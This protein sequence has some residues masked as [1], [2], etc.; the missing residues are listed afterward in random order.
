M[1]EWNKRNRELI[2]VTFIGGHRPDEDLVICCDAQEIPTAV[3]GGMVWDLNPLRLKANFINCLRF[4]SIFDCE[5]AHTKELLE[6]VKYLLFCMI[7]FAK[8]GAA[9]RLSAEVVIKY[10]NLLRRAAR[11]C[12]A[13]GEKPLVGVLSLQDLFTNPIYLASFIR[14]QGEKGTG[15]TQRKALKAI[16]M[17]MVSFGEE[18]LGYRL[19]G[20]FDLDFDVHADHKQH[21]VIPLRIYFRY[22]GLFSEYLDHISLYAR[23][24]SAFLRECKDPAYACSHKCQ[25]NTHRLFNGEYKLDFRQAMEIHG[26][27]GFFVDDF[28]CSGRQFLSGVVLRAQFYLKMIIHAYTGMRDQEVMR[29]RYDCLRAAVVREPLFAEDSSV[30]DPPQIIEVLSSTTKFAGYDQAASWIATEEVVKAVELAQ[31]LC[32]EL[33]GIYD[34]DLD[35]APLFISPAVLS[36]RVAKGGVSAW[37]KDGRPGSIS[38]VFIEPDDL[39]QLCLSDQER[40]FLS[41]ERFSVGSPWPLTSHQFR[42]SLVFYGSSSGLISLPSMKRQMKHVSLSM[43]RYYR[44]GFEKI[45]SVFGYF[46]TDKGEYV[47]PKSHVA[48]DFQMAM[49]IG[50][51]YDL[52]T[53]VF[54][55]ESPLFGGVGSYVE[56]QR[57]VI[58]NGVSVAD[59][60]KETQRLVDSGRM[61]YRRTLLGGCTKVGECDSYMLGDVTA[62]LECDGAVINLRQL[63]E[64]RMDSEQELKLYPADSGEYQIILREL[65]CLNGF[66]KRHVQDKGLDNE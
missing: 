42:R 36:R 5:D 63:K 7:F 49:P 9:G 38:S 15:L 58:G 19:R 1:N 64:A 16:L 25:N 48:F 12:Y 66:Y 56:K 45:S 30:I 46:D 55:E 29:M 37:D 8:G 6:E 31:M 60:R 28:A 26:L 17:H 3:Y 18:R 33:C 41:D 24:L 65:E 14:S 43:T 4:C 11:F 22:L 61:A 57:S 32:R 53:N 50:V 35:G 21:P 54:G 2:S 23:R 44:K 51:A 10:F 47:L 39:H 59:L 40:D 27:K 62:C 34:I 52:L 13:Q 20:V